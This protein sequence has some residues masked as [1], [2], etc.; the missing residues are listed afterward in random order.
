M[1]QF[2]YTAITAEGQKVTGTETAESERDLGRILYEKGH[3]LTTVKAGEKGKLELPTLKEAFS[4]LQRVSLMEKLM[5]T[6][7][8]QVMV[9]AGIPLPKALDVLA[10]QTESSKF[11]RVI[12]DVKKRVVEGQ[13]LSLSMEAYPHVFS[14]LF[15]NMVKVG[16]ESGTLEN[17][18]SQ[19]TVQLE[20]QH[21]LKSK[22]M[23]ALLYPSVVITAMI[24]I[25]VLMLIAVIPKLAETFEELGAELPLTTRVV[26]GLSRFLASYWF[27]VF[28][29][30]L[31]LLV[32]LFRFIQTGTGKRLFGQLLLHAPVFSGIVRKFNAALMTRTIS[33]LIEAGVP[34][35]RG[36]EI[37]SKV[38]GNSFF[39]DSL[40]EAAVRVGKGSRLS[41]VL[42][43]Y[44]SLYPVIVI[45]MVEVGEETG[46]TGSILAKLAEFYEEEVTQVT[47]N[48]T[49]IIEPIL[50]LI[51]G[52]AVGFFAVSMIQPMYSMLGA[53]Q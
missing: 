4:F 26:I 7:N 15:T 47:K 22:I 21:E 29:I 35:V 2:T 25:G 13:T 34:L 33:S 27:I 50:M 32:L 52:A 49:S 51:I 6:R 30:V 20:R 9:A 3:I 8:L 39:E 38:V 1:P 48:L 44:R 53:I 42:R 43:E 12:I 11:R 36:L 31:V 19:L 18:L 40:K 28:P 46:E 5:F 24:G 45:Q 17:V 23:G 37:T 16:E 14:E 10:E 41:E